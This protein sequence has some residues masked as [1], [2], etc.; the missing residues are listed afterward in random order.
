MSKKSAKQE[1]TLSR[2]QL[3][4]TLCCKVW[5]PNPSHNLMAASNRHMQTPLVLCMLDSVHGGNQ[6]RMVSHVP[7][8]IISGNELFRTLAP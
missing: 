1:E 4:S 8:T 6:K 2:N 5:R 3:S 7:I